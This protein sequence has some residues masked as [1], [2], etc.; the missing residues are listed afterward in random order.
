MCLPPPVL[1]CRPAPL[2]A[3]P[4]PLAGPA[5]PLARPAVPLAR[6][7]PLPGPAVPVPGAAAAL[8]GPPVP[9]ARPAAP[10][11]RPGA[12][13]VAGPAA[14]LARAH[15]Q[16]LARPAAP[17]P[18]PAAL[19]VPGLGVPAPA[20]WREDGAGLRQ[21]LQPPHQGR[22]PGPPQLLGGEQR[23]P[24]PA[25]P[26]ALA[27]A[28][29][30]DAPQAPALRR[31]VPGGHGGP[32]ERPRALRGARALREAVVGRRGLGG[33]QPPQPRGGGCPLRLLLRRLPHPRRR[34]APGSCRLCQDRARPVLALDQRKRHPCPPQGPGRWVGAGRGRDPSSWQ[35]CS[36]PR[37]PPRL[38]S[39]RPAKEHD[40]GRGLGARIGP[41]PCGGGLRAAPVPTAADGDGGLG[42]PELPAVP[43]GLPHRLPGRCFDKAH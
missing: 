13:P 26:L 19:P 3:V 27:A 41:G 33:P 9:V 32:P 24:V 23:G 11:A 40:G 22:L 8:P 20:A 7:R 35:P 1:R 25:E 6:A 16:P 14:P 18:G 10:L 38:P 39:P 15:L 36:V 37:F 12:L 30:L 21:A 31:G 2:P 42:N 43:A 4:V 5:A 17:L 29:S 28:R 34:R